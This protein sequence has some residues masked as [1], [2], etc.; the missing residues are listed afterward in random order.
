M[1]GD[2]RDWEIG[3]NAPEGKADT[4]VGQPYCPPPEYCCVVP[5]DKGLGTKGQEK[6]NAQA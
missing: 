5:G 3:Y 4:A 1:T 2:K 6:P